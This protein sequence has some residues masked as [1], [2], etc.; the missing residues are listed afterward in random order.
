MSK[1]TLYAMV[2]STLVL[3]M[4]AACAVSAAP[5][6][7]YDYD[8]PVEAEEAPA[9]ERVVADEREAEWADEEGKVASGS[10]A[11]NYAAIER[12]IVRNASLDIVVLDTQEA[13]DAINEMTEELGGYVVE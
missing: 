13:L 7:G 9:V 11:A 2:I 8:Y 5:E 4:V 3:V 1:R 6:A 10:G 12:L